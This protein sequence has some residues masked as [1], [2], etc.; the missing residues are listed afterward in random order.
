MIQELCAFFLG[1]VSIPISPSRLGADH[2][3]GNK[4]ARQY[5]LNRI[6]VMGGFNDDTD[7]LNTREVSS[8]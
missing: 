4:L 8:K 5:A 6:F 7:Y 1:V 3:H 2:L